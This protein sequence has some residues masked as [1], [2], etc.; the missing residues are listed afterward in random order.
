LKTL[1]KEGIPLQLSSL[2]GTITSTA[3][4]IIITKFFGLE[5]TGYYSLA[6]SV[7]NYIYETPNSF[8][9]IMFPRFQ[10]RYAESKNDLTALF[11]YIEKPILGLVLF[12]L[13]ITIG[14]SYFLLNFI[15]RQFLFEYLTTLDFLYYF[16][17][18]VFIISLS[19]MPGQFL[20]TIGKLWH[21]ICLGLVS[22]S[23]L[24]FCMLVPAYTQGNIISIVIGYSLGHSIIFTMLIIYVYS[25]INNIKAGLVLL[26]KIFLGMTYTFLGLL[27]V[28][29]SIQIHNN[30]KVFI[31]I[32][33]TLLS[34]LFYLI[35]LTPLLYYSNKKLDLLK[36]L[37]DIII[38]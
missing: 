10:E 4:L 17:M 36:K 26:N 2:I 37:K 14:L 38:K 20:I 31:D 22:F 5:F 3:D 27:L 24:I 9:V 33:N 19:H 12:Y 29:N 15:I 1:L 7:K 28:G 30:V 8:S 13:P 34:I 25:Q 32:Q 11:S 18:G 21:R 23:I 35:W 16:F 6:L